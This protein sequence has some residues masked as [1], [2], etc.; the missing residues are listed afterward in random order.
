V[1]LSRTRVND[2]SAIHGRSEQER[3]W[4]TRTEPRAPAG[5]PVVGLSVQM[6]LDQLPDYDARRRILAHDPLASVDGFRILVALAYQHLFG[7]RVCLSCADCNNGDNSTPCQ[8][9]FGSNAQPEGGTFGRVDAIYTSIEA[10]KSTGSLHAHC[11]VFVECLHQHTP[12]AEVL[13]TLQQNGTQT[14]RDYLRYKV[15]VCRQTYEAS[16]PDIEKKLPGIEAEWPSYKQKTLLMETP[17]YQTRTTEQYT[18]IENDDGQKWLQEYLHEHVDTLQLHKQH[19]IHLPNEDT[20]IREPLPGCRRKDKPSVCKADFP[21]TLWIIDKAVV[22][23]RGLLEKWAWRCQD[24]GAN[25]AA[26]MAP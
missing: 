4:C 12:L 6:L 20:G 25:S 21:R 22:L 13:T 17:P 10:Q 1:R 14:V 2:P 24:D 26:C 23:C 18:A 8:D 19:H 9:Y 15:H 7:I 16:G 11:Q 3:R 5:E